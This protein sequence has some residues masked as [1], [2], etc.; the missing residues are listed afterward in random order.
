MEK[1]TSNSNTPE[2]LQIEVGLSRN[3]PKKNISK[4]VKFLL[5]FGGV[6][7]AALMIAAISLIYTLNVFSKELGIKNYP[8]LISN[9]INTP[10]SQILSAG[11]RTNILV[12]GKG[13]AGH[14]APDL[15]DTV[16]FV[17]VALFA[18]QNP[19]V[20]VSLPRDLWIP[21]IRAKVNSSYYW[22][23]QKK[24]GGGLNFA[25]TEVQEIVGQ[26]I[27]YAIVIDFSGFKK[28]ID[29]IGGIEVNVER[30]FV[31]EHYPIAGRE[32]D[33]C[34]GDK[35]YKCRYETVRFEKGLKHLDGET[36][37]KFVRSRYAVGDE[38]TDFARTARQEKIITAIKKKI[39]TGEILL[40]PM[41]LTGI[42]KAVNSSIETDMDQNVMAIIVR[43][44]I[45]NKGNVSTNVLL[46]ELLINPPINKKFDN[47]YVFVPKAGTWVEVQNWFK[48]ILY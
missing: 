35:L 13:G 26:P 5:I 48:K 41:R 2:S 12:L 19:I 3:A 8:G 21:D 29:A 28:I 6:F 42:A 7:C 34:G 4:R 24:P 16:I 46:Q 20:L 30:S 31:D 17:S 38:G 1:S 9:F 25:K 43:K 45:D 23:N 15:T 10:F 27:H 37:L 44:I 14:D 47:Q 11:G 18:S 39:F 36:A 33:P 22:G 32:D 40:N